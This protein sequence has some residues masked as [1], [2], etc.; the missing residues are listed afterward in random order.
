MLSHKSGNICVSVL[1]AAELIPEHR[2]TLAYWLMQLDEIDWDDSTTGF[3]RSQAKIYDY[4][5][6]TLVVKLGTYPLQFDLSHQEITKVLARGRIFESL[7]RFHVKA[8][9]TSKFILKLD[10]HRGCLREIESLRD[11][12]DA[13]PLPNLITVKVKQ[14]PL[15]PMEIVQGDGDNDTSSEEGI[16]ISSGLSSSPSDKR[17][18]NPTTFKIERNENLR[19]MTDIECILAVPRV[20]GFDLNNKEWCEFNVDDIRDA[21]WDETP[22]KNLVLPPGE[23]DLMF[24]SADRARHSKEKF[25]NFVHQKGNMGIIILLCGPSGVGK[26]LTAEAAAEFSRVPLYVLTASDLG[27]NLAH[28][29]SALIKALEQ[30]RLWD[31]LLLDEADVF[32]ERRDSNNLD[33]NELVSTE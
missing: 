7:R 21:G 19:P 32:L 14:K 1:R 30:C 31:A 26:I 16:V 4:E 3:K 17:P 23:K 22:F 20:K 25:D 33:R 13:Q 2:D 10:P 15:D 9:N 18:E 6:P 11:S 5:E 24:E 12:M 27:T 28:V 8:C 29:N